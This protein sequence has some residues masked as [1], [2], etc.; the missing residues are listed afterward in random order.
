MPLDV[1]LDRRREA[2]R[3]GDCVRGAERRELRGRRRAPSGVGRG[4]D[5][6]LLCLRSAAE[7]GAQLLDVGADACIERRYGALLKTLPARPISENVYFAVG[8]A[9]LTPESR[10]AAK[11]LVSN[12]KSYVAPQVSVTGHADA[13]GSADVNEALSKK[14]AETVRAYLI[15]LGVP[16]DAMELTWRGARDPAVKI[17]E[18]QA[19]QLNRRVEIRLR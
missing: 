6:L 10:A 16:P 1:G 17:D 7:V 8:S 19:E 5:V 14:R 13:T 4:A 15:E 12:L 3:G 11:A 18:R 9:E 2:L